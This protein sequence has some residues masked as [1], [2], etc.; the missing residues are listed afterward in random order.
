MIK[1]NILKN[2]SAALLSLSFLAPPAIAGTPVKPTEE[3]PPIEESKPSVVSGW[4]SFDLNSHFMSY[5]LDVWAAGNRFSKGTF[6]PSLELSLALPLEGLSAIVGTF[7]DIN[8][9]AESNIGGWIQE[10][11]VWAG[12]SYSWK[13]LSATVLYQA[14]NYGS[15]TEHILD[16]TLKYANNLFLNPAFTLHTRMGAELE[17][18]GGVGPSNSGVFFVPNLSYDLEIWKF[19]ITPSAAMG[20]C[21]DDFHGGEGGYAYTALGISASVPIPYLPGDWELHGGVTYYNTNPDVIPTNPKNNFITANVGV[22]L[23]F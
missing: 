22:K 21:T 15:Q 12:L 1:K 5:G 23:S 19:T 10:V 16:V 11:D 7:W 8:N 20:F 4:I 18:P 2:L 3:A 17:G 13:D 14:W 6:N 9:N